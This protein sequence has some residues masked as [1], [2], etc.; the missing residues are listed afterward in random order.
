MERTQEGV[1]GGEIFPAEKKRHLQSRIRHQCRREE[2]ERGK[3][4]R[5]SRDELSLRDQSC[6]GESGLSGSHVNKLRRR[7]MCVPGQR[8]HAG[9][10][11]F[12]PTP[13]RV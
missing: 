1:A 11:S 8:T 4:S 6:N 7:L 9:K 12:R 2:F 13:L 10:G 3:L 5:R